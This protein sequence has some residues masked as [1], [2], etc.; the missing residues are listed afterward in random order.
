MSRS[1]TALLALLLAVVLVP[2]LGACIP[3]S[4]GTT[5]MPVARDTTHTSLLVT[6]LPSVGVIDSTRGASYLS[7]DAEVRRG[8][9]SVSDFGLRAV[10][11][12]SGVVVN[13]K[14]LLTRTNEPVMIAVMPGIGFL[15]VG[16][17]AHFELTLLASRREARVVNGRTERLRIVPYGGLR[18]MQVAPLDRYAVHDEPTVGAFAGIRLGTNTLGISP[19]VG[20]FHDR[21]VLGHRQSSV[22]VVPTIA[23]HGD[24]LLEMLGRAGRAGGIIRPGW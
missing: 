1:R 14:R 10:S 17:H 21:S 7:A 22:V 11:G 5:A 3:Y 8:I 20:V 18:G 19:E 23:V 12:L 6:V 2:F 9:D 16:R 4:V 15:N 24:D 13:Y